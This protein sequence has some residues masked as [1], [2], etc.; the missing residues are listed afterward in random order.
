MFIEGYSVNKGITDIILPKHYPVLRLSGCVE[1]I[2]CIE[3]KELSSSDATPNWFE[4]YT[5]EENEGYIATAIIWM[6]FELVMA[7]WKRLQ[8]N[9]NLM[10]VQ[11]WPIPLHC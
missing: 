4:G 6:S 10:A 9:N 2:H 8:G 11:C 1:V 3:C 5:Y 7:R